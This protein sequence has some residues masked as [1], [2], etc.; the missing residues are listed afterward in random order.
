LK[1]WLWS[2]GACDDSAKFT[3]KLKVRNA[4]KAVARSSFYSWRG[5]WLIGGGRAGFVARNGPQFARRARSISSRIH[6]SWQS[7]VGLWQKTAG[8]RRAILYRVLSLICF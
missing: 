6:F 3:P 1:K 4:I 7:R 8:N 2:F 5:F